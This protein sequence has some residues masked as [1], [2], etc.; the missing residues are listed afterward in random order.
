RDDLVTGV[1]TCALPILQ[2]RN[3][4][5]HCSYAR[6]PRNAFRA[7]VVISVIRLITARTAGE[8]P[9]SRLNSSQSSRL[10]G[11]GSVGTSTSSGSWRSEERRV[12]NGGEGVGG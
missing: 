1:Q 7:A 5:V 6:P 10:G 2:V 12:G 11:G 9:T 8:R 3:A 4:R